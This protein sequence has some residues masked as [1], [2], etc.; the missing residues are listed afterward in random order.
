MK[1]KTI[2]LWFR[3]DLRLH[4]NVIVHEA[5]RKNALVIPVYC[6]NPFFYR[7]TKIGTLKTGSFRSRFIF[8]SVLALRENLREKGTD[9]A[10]VIGKPE[11]EICKL[12]IKYN[13]EDVYVHQEVASEEN[14]EME[15]VEKALWKHRIPLTSFIG[16]TLY[17]K[18]DLPFPIRDIPDTFTLFRKK[19]EKETT[20]REEYPSPEKMESPFFEEINHLPDLN[21]LAL[22]LDVEIPKFEN[23]FPGGENHALARLNYYLWEAD[24]IKNYKVTRNN[25]LGNDCSTKLSPYLSAG[26]I[27]P[28]RIYHEVKKYE[29][30][31]IANDSTYELIFELLWRDYFRFMFKK[32][33]NKFFQE[34]GFQ[35]KT[36]S[37][38]IDQKESFEKWKDGKTGIPFIDACMIELNTTGFMSNSGRQNAASFLVKNLQVNWTW[39]AC[40]FEE[41]LIDYSPSSNWGNWASIA[42]VGNEPGKNGLFSV[43]KQAKDYDPDGTF[44]QY[45]N[46]LLN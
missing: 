22:K 42:G 18:Q 6:F 10:I 29:S 37:F 36:L 39:G 20:V 17:H 26:C 33:G 24:L 32:H 3:N 7:K 5:V 43:E 12:A 16:H 35:K 23:Q 14:I 25:L 4:D 13:V 1:Q 30:E 8:E 15:K 31:R 46:N 45:W 2:L 40:Y 44:T 9:L 21:T 27:S 11:E 41:K 34:S 19:I 28:R 38:S